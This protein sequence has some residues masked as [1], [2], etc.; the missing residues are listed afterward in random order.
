M[1]RSSMM[2]RRAGW[3][4]LLTGLLE[5]ALT[6]GFWFL[7]GALPGGAGGMLVTAAILGLD[8]HPSPGHR[9]RPPATRSR[10][11]PDQR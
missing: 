10:D 4:L 2:G 5:L 6:G 8:R 11:R 1:Y 7:A 3:A 9:G